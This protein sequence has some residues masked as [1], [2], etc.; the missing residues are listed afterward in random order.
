MKQKI[1]ILTLFIICQTAC[2][3]TPKESF[4]SELDGHWSLSAVMCSDPA[5]AERLNKR[6]KNDAYQVNW[7][8]H[9]REFR[10]HMVSIEKDR[11]LF[12]QRS[13]GVYLL[14]Q[15]QKIRL[16]ESG[17]RVSDGELNSRDFDYHLQDGQL[18]IESNDICAGDPGSLIFQRRDNFI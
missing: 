1:G 4:I 2:T 9:N 15:T 12:T 8:F 7:S 5:V 13:Q 14:D 16:T 3:T 6:I 11:R 10:H 17:P 18:S